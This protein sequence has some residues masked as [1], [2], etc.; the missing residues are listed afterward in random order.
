MEKSSPQSA[1]SEILRVT[2]S[3]YQGVLD[4]VIAQRPGPNLKSGSHTSVRTRRIF[5]LSLVMKK[6]LFHSM[7]ALNLPSYEAAAGISSNQKNPSALV[8]RA[9]LISVW[10]GMKP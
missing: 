6:L 4:N 8:R 7:G 10:V 5:M 3:Q 2:V 1:S 9:R